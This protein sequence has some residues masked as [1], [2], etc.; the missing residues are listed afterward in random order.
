MQEYPVYIVNSKIIYPSNFHSNFCKFNMAIVF[1]E[2]VQR[3]F[4][5]CFQL[6]AKLNQYHMSLHENVRVLISDTRKEA[7][8]MLE[9]L[10]DKAPNSAAE[11]R[12]RIM[13]DKVSFFNIGKW[14]L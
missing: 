12:L 2:L 14:C 3:L 1:Q 13:N 10:R 7:V 9:K 5:Q 8:A 11:E 6:K 4:E